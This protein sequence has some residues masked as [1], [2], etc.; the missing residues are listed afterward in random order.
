[1][2]ADSFCVHCK[3]IKLCMHLKPVLAKSR[4]LLDRIFRPVGCDTFVRVEDDVIW[5]ALPFLQRASDSEDTHS[6]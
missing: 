1:M 6:G 5:G 4:F 3:E 2:P